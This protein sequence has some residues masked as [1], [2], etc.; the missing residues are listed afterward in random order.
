[1]PKLTKKSNHSRI[2]FLGIDPG[3]KGGI[4][5][6]VGDTAAAWPMPTTDTD[7]FDLLKAIKDGSVPNKLFAT[8]EHVHSMPKQGVKSVFTFGYGYGGLCMDLVALRISFQEVTPRVW[9]KTF[10]QA[11]RGEDKTKYKNLL[12]TKAQ[13]LFPDVDGITLSTCDALLIAE[14]NRRTYGKS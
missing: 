7:I 3:K 10:T 9:Q 13:R 6:V 14:F 12:K 4:A 5:V 2:G 8:I 1:M 11:K